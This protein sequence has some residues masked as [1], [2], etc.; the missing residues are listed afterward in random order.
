MSVS[1]ASVRRTEVGKVVVRSESG[2]GGGESAGAGRGGNVRAV[3]EESA[4][5]RMVPC[6][7]RVGVC[8]GMCKQSRHSQGLWRTRMR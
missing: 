3:N 7:A 2:V 4:R 8:V 6:R 5:G 1:I